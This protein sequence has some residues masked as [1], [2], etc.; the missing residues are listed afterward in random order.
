MARAVKVYVALSDA[1]YVVLVAVVC[2]KLN[3]VH[4]APF[5]VQVTVYEERLDADET[6]AMV[7]V[8]VAVR[9][10]LD[11]RDEEH[12]ETERDTV[13]AGLAGT[14]AGAGSALCVAILDG[15]STGRTISETGV[16]VPDTDAGSLGGALLGGGL[17]S[18]G[19]ETSDVSAACL[20]TGFPSGTVGGGDDISTTASFS[21]GVTSETLSDLNLVW[22]TGGGR[23]SSSSKSSRVTELP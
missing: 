20:E 17:S 2:E 13:G 8:V 9:H 11:A 7:R 3:P 16:D 21:G 4:A 15:G 10:P 19:S 14:A 12:S 5:T 22:V 6:H 23:G 1:P 18:R